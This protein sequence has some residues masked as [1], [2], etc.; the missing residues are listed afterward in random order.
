MHHAVLILLQH[1]FDFGKASFANMKAKRLSYRNKFI[2]DIDDEELAEYIKKSQKSGR[3]VSESDLI[4][5]WEYDMP[6]KDIKYYHF[7]KPDSFNT[8]MKMYYDNPFYSG[9]IIVTHIIGGR[10]ALNGDSLTLRYSPESIKV[11]VDRSGIS[12]RAQMRDSVESFIG[13]YF[14]KDR[15][16]EWLRRGLKSNLRKNTYGIS[17][18]RAGDK[19]ELE[20]GRGDNSENL[21]VSYI[22][23]KPSK[24]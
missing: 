16:V 10:W 19:I 20:V 6:G 22:Y 11:E 15:L 24:E 7:M 9:A 23:L 18:N 3:P 13:N 8:T 2:M 12:Y 14:Q 4:G 1:L 17:T 5:D 21:E